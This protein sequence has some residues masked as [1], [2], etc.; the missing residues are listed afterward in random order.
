ML[1][2]VFKKIKSG[3]H[4]YGNNWARLKNH[5]GITWATLDARTRMLEQPPT[6]IDP[7]MTAAGHADEGENAWV[8]C[9]IRPTPSR[10]ACPLDKALPSNLLK[11]KHN[12]WSLS[13]DDPLNYCC[14]SKDIRSVSFS[15]NNFDPDRSRHLG[16]FSHFDHKIIAF[17]VSLPV[18][19]K[20]AI[21]S[22]S[23]ILQKPH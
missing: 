12:K 15:A 5:Y 9:S 21:L 18:Y 11:C 6:R 17:R 10:I 13:S 1:L 8:I 4:H 14:A 20:H 7:A 3:D 2:G 22:D 23:I 19:L 16:I